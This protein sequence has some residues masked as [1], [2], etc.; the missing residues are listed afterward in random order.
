[1]TRKNFR[2]SENLAGLALLA[3]IFLFAGCDQGVGGSGLTLRGTVTISEM[4]HVGQ[5]LE[6]DVSG[7]EVPEGTTSGL[8]QYKWQKKGAD[9]GDKW[10]AIYDEDDI[11]GNK[12]SYTPVVGDID[13]NIRV[14]VSVTGYGNSVASNETSPVTQAGSGDTIY[15]AT[16]DGE[17]NLMTSTKINFT[18]G[19]AVSG[20][21]AADITI[22]GGTGA[23]T[24]GDLTG[25]GQNWLLPITVTTAGNITVS[26]TKTGIESMGKPVTVF[27]AGTITSISYTAAADGDATKA[28]TKIDFTFGAAVSGLTATDIT[29]TGGTGAVTAGDLTGSGQ[30]WSLPITV[31]TAG[32][33]TVSISKTG[34]ENTGKS[35]AVYA[36]SDTTYNI[37]YELAGGTNADGNP[38]TYTIND[39][40]IEL[41]DP[42]LEYHNFVGW[43]ADAGFTE[44]KVT[45]INTGNKGIETLYAKWTAITFTITFDSQGGTDVTAI[46]ADG[47]TEVTEPADPAKT[48]YTFT[49]WYSAATGGTLYPWPHTITEDITMYAQWQ[50][51]N[52]PP[53]DQYTITFNSQ[54][55]SDV[56]PVEAASGTNVGQ[57]ADPTK[58]GHTFTGW[59]DAATGGAK[60]NWPYTLTGDVTMY[61]QW[62]VSS[63]SIT[64]NL[65]GGTNAAD[66]PSSYTIATAAITLPTP[67]RSGYTFA[68]WFDNSSLTGSAVTQIPAGS[69][70]NK[71]FWAKWTTV[72]TYAAVAD[73]DA[74]T[75]STQINFTFGAA[76][77]GLTAADINITSGTGAVTTGDLTG[78]GTS[79]SL[80]ITVT[81]AG[82]ITV[83]I[84]KTGIEA[85]T[86][87]VTVYKAS[88]PPT[89]HQPVVMEKNA[90]HQF[91]TTLTD[92]TWAVTGA[93]DAGTTISN[94]GLLTVSATETNITLSVT[95]TS[96]GNVE[97][98]PVKVKG[99]MAVA[100]AKSIF[101]DDEIYGIA[102]GGGKWVA[103]GGGGGGKIAYS[104]DGEQ[105]EEATISG[106]SDSL[107]GVV[108]GGG[109]FVAV[110]N[111]GTILYSADGVSWAKPTIGVS[112]DIEIST[113]AYGDNKFI[114]L[115][116]LTGANE[117][118]G[119]LTST[120]GNEWSS[121][122]AGS[123]FNIVWFSSNKI[124]FDG[125]NFI[126]ALGPNGAI[127]KIVYEADN[128]PNIELIANY[129]KT[130]SPAL[131]LTGYSTD[132][133]SNVPETQDV[134]FTG[135]QWITVEKRGWVA[136]SEDT[137]SWEAVRIS[138]VTTALGNSQGIYAAAYGNGKVIAGGYRGHFAY[139]NLQNTTSGKITA[140]LSLWTLK[141]MYTD[142]GVW[143][144]STGAYGVNIQDIG[145][146]GGKFIVAGLNG[147]MAIAYE[148]TLD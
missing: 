16:A 24:A 73:G 41:S 75:T 10:E 39:L 93:K 68:G 103:V 18:F 146:A 46:T 58:A 125:A 45:E 94:T 14:L 83:S 140:D 66:P 65:N 141:D 52:V 57:P 50:E 85:G 89:P 119:I 74:T 28:S 38:Q 15:T 8:Y 123:P 63:Y 131:S 54:G 145:Y 32:N 92:A 112:S 126:M 97:S 51:N 106:G 20:L 47:G 108:Y 4:A 99:W 115:G 17:N 127:G 101:G 70:G 88:A 143:V 113:V 62:T 23:V 98:Y 91:T 12:D 109:K 27:K 105:W 26:I 77:S 61:A 129:S 117:G 128:K 116:Y 124:K 55:G 76:V 104:T 5:T 7:L 35:V 135:T 107:A 142:E 44:P 133:I 49:G 31:T 102:Y 36:Q 148:E 1:M 84:S 25:S 79:W 139:V 87:G 81:T 120:D 110:G 22:I 138:S 43:Y 21:T 90:S 42:T 34:I 59:F 132:V 130:S 48:N 78:G 80:A 40:P 56:A 60:H 137:T 9:E 3:A 29:I 144:K 64:Y 72:I 136:F 71:T 121:T 2:F 114:A 118:I 11:T 69:T 134:I 13:Y 67:T 53:P 95:A 33:I 19:A 111:S 37:S 96:G 86:K 6:A 147:A 100:S 122:N 30:N 82:N